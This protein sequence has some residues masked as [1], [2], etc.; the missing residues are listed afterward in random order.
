M[1]W[2]IVAYLRALGFEGLRNSGK[3][4]ADA[5]SAVLGEHAG[6]AMSLLVMISALGGLNGLILAVSRVHATV[7]ADHALFSWLGY[8][9]PRYK[10]RCDRCSLKAWSRS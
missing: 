9:S 4:A 2:S 8:W 7:G 5:F 3:P 1:C 6:R 10:L